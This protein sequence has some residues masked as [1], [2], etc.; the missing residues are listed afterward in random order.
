MKF[1]KHVITLILF[2]CIVFTGNSFS[3]ESGRNYLGLSF[4]GSDFHIKDE[5]ASP[6][7]FSSTGIAPSI[8]YIYQG[9]NSR[10][11]AEASY[12][13]DYLG[14]SSDNFHDINHRA[15]IR[16][17]YLH[18]IADFEIL[19]KKINVFVG[20]SIGTFLSHSDYTNIWVAS[21][22][23]RTIESWYWNNSFD[24]SAQLE[25]NL[26][27]RE[28]FSIKLFIPVVSN[29]S[30]PTYSSSGDFN[31]TDNDWKFKMFGETKFFPAIF[32][33]NTLLTYQRPLIW[34]LNLQ[35]NYEFYYS[36][37]DKPRNI[38]MY[39]NNLCAGLFFC[40]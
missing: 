35:I 32:S 34:K 31:Y 25:Y 27:P 19:N 18:S 3:Q 40:F 22:I 14:T 12:Y 33:V 6:L 8:Q 28:F 26:E 10:V 20:G 13:Y 1:K 37:Y 2:Y 15:E 7:I 9:E 21:T 24:V 30:R 17:S 29:L 36:S 23:S 16:C 5:H 39:M 38:N 11:Y 4:G